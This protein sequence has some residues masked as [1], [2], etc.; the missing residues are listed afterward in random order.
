MP[1]TSSAIFLLLMFI[2]LIK[3][4][5]HSTIFFFATTVSFF[6]RGKAITVLQLSLR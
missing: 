5:T 2:I 4:F 3:G 1:K 6:Q